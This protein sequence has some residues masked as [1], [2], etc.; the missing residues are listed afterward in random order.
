VT[1]S[2]VWDEAAVPHGSPTGLNLTQTCHFRSRVDRTSPREN[3]D[4]FRAAWNITVY[5]LS[6]NH[7][8][9]IDLCVAPIVG[10]DTVF[11]I[12]ANDTVTL[13]NVNKTSLTAS[14]FHFT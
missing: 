8:D 5:P 7:W 13:D 14:N 1:A 2:A 12:D 11:T 10:A 6:I 4:K 9:T 3:G